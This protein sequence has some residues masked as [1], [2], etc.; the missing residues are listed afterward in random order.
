MRLTHRDTLEIHEIARE[1]LS[2]AN[3]LRASQ[4]FVASSELERLANQLTHYA[5]S[6]ERSAGKPFELK[7]K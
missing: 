2:R 4:Q 3:E 6:V 7:S 5:G 1:I